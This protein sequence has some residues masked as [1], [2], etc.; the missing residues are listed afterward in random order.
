M[1]YRYL[2]ELPAGRNQVRFPHYI[3]EASGY[4]AGCLLFIIR[5]RIH[6][7][8][9]IIVSGKNAILVI[10]EGNHS[11]LPYELGRNFFI[12]L[13]NSRA[14]TRDKSDKPIDMYAMMLYTLEIPTIS[15]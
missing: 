14:M 8:A 11:L 6:T 10:K 4:Q 12:H 1:A 3:K 13:P 2:L 5:V 7:V 15:I 9:N